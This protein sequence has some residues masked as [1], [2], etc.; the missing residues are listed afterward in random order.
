MEHNGVR[1]TLGGIDP[2][3][4][5]K[6]F[7]VNKGNYIFFGDDQRL[8]ADMKL[9]ADDGMGVKIYSNDSTE[10]LQDITVGLTRFD[11]AKV[12]STLSTIPATTSPYRL[13]SAWRRCHTR[14]VL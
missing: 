5:Y 1:L 3:L 7:K 11:L 6:E 12:L 8:S 2:V 4:G 14:A 9:S 10:A 13:P